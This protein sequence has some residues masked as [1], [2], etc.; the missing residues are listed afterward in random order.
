MK[1][2]LFC[3]VLC[4]PLLTGCALFDFFKKREEPVIP[5]DRVVHVDPKLLE[6]CKPLVKLE[7]VDPKSVDFG[8][9]VLTNLATNAAIYSE[10]AKKQDGSITIIKEFANNKENK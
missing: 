10:C 5:R 4:V 3:I 9:Q 8:N 1:K 6:P 7:K 2:A